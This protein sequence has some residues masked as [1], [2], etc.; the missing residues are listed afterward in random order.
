MS[1]AA[2]GIAADQ[3]LI[4]EAAR[5]AGALA[6]R[7]FRADNQVWHKNGNSPVSEADYA[8]DRF[9]SQTLRAAR[10]DYGWL[11]EETEDSAER[12]ETNRL[13]VVDPID[14]TRGFLDGRREWCV[15]VAIVEAGRPVAGVLECPALG[16]TYAALAGGGA[17]RNGAP[18][19]RISG[20]AI[21]S[22][23]ASRKLNEAIRAVHGDGLAILPFVPSL[24]YR[25]AMVADSRVDGAFARSGA[26]D[27]DLAAA[28]IILSE[29]GGAMVDTGGEALRYNRRSPKHGSLL[30][31]G[32]NR[33]ERLMALAKQG[34]F[35]H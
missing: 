29:S 8:V 27:W 11:S 24:A 2:Q 30:A 17:T 34:R 18:I 28:D 26:C 6:A 20:G 19:A 16:E 35:L 15:S 9:L 32:S 10:P 13:F 4:V 23:T 21:T 33:I 7:Y 14:G 25:L 5:E 12:L 22:L 1:S 3:A 31:A